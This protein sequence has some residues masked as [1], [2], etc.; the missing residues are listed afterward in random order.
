M[1]L[2]SKRLICETKGKSFYNSMI[3]M[4]M[5]SLNELK[6]MYTNDYYLF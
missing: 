5:V 2:S 4:K 1:F 3:K 6:N